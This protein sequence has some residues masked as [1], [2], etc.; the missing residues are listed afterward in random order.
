MSVTAYD[1]ADD[2]STTAVTDNI[3][4]IMTKDEGLMAGK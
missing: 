2:G 1:I 4:V 3:L